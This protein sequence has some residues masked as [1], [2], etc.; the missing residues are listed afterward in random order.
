MNG[1]TRLPERSRPGPAA[2]AI[3]ARER[4]DGAPD[5]I[6]LEV[7]RNALDSLADE[8][9]LVL[10]RTAYSPVVRDSMDY[11]TAFCDRDG[12]MV[13]QG[14]TT[15]LH[16]GSFPDAMHALAQRYGNAI[17][18]G[19]L[20]VLNDP[21]GSGGMHL[22]DIY[23]IKPV[24]HEGAV[25]GYATTLV[26]HTDIGGIT[27]GGTAVHATEIFQEGLRIPLMRLA[28]DGHENETL[29]T[30]LA[31]NV[32]VPDRV[33]G[34]L[35]A[36][37]AAC[38]GAERGYVRL[39]QRY[40]A[41]QVRACIARLHDIAESHMRDTIRA[42]PDGDY[43]FTDWI[44]GFGHTPAPI[45]FEVTVT[46][47][48]DQATVDWTG[49][50]P[51]VDGA[52]NAPGPFIRSASYL[53]FRCLVD[54]RIPNTVGYMRPIHVVAPEGT[55]VNPHFPAACNARGIVG[56]RAIDTLFGALAQAVPGRV[57]AAGEGGATNP[58]IGG[59]LDGRPFVFT[60]TILGSWGGRPDR[61]GLDGAANLAANQS[62]QP[63]E[64]L[65]ADAPV[66]IVD[67]GLARN[68]GGPG[69]FRGG[70]AVRRTYR[71]LAPRGVFTLR[72]DRRKHLPY[73]L[74]DGASG[75]PSYTVLHRRGATS[76]LPVL[77]LDKIDVEAG[78][79]IVHVQPGGG[80]YGDPLERE[81]DAVLQDVLD[82]RCDAAYARAVYG[83]CIESSQ[84]DV[85]ATDALRGSMRRAPDLPPQRHLDFFPVATATKPLHDA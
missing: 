28:E 70:M 2:D 62:N 20:F 10:M 37:I 52:I 83:V 12:H 55:I 17:R 80:G 66:Q 1:P 60:E 33:I 38:R 48:G 74:A 11:S 61:D 69:R 31:A 3:E 59:M 49:T 29:L 32:R 64:M 79:L 56:F 39:L 21:Y 22:P 35:R 26:H 45:R 47:A 8:M 9:A 46:V 67:Y 4:A 71:I 78:D 75:T 7:V 16:L 41:A 23:V 81:P 72:S 30:L 19:D 42:L 85:R 44:D 82:D 84:V 24:F 76:L 25:E 53:A 40:G 18:E 77:P 15:A 13:A 6:T 5:P 50:S 65:E 51:Q 14:L 34:D 58:S 73:G 68:S 43:R 57:Y 63:V 27:P 36:Q 54:T